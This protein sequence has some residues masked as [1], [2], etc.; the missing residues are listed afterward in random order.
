MAISNR[1]WGDITQADYR[2]AEHYCRSS[3]INLNEGD[4]AT[5]AKERCKL[6]VYEPGG[7]LNRNAVHAAAAV[8][9]GSRGGVNAP[10]AAKRRAAQR[11]V[12][13]Y[14]ELDEVPP[15]SLVTLAT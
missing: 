5:W 6:P 1:P 15:V 4:P 10:A 13:L 7:A 9:A 11:L 12:A 3:L 14:R 8:L 2:D